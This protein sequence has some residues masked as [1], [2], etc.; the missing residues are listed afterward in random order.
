MFTCQSTAK[1]VGLFNMCGRFALQPG[2]KFYDRFNIENRLDALVERNNITPGQMVPVIMSKSPNRVELMKWGLIPHWA[3]EKN[4][5]YKMINARIE[6]LVEKPS[7]RGPLKSKRCLVPASGFYEWQATRFG[8][9]PYFIH[10]KNEPLFSFAGLYDVW[11][12]G[13]DDGKVE[14]IY[15]FTIITKNANKT[16]SKI[17]DRMP[18]ILEQSRE[19]EWLDR[20][21]QDTIK[22]LSILNC[23][24]EDKI[25]I[26]PADL[27]G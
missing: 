4:I 6:T 23:D 3:K 17:H 27:R 8:K 9:T 10:L 1:V 5:G 26:Y 24:Y 20:D 14:K 7:Y 11:T 21:L 16:I 25:E 2:D 19:S 15:S 12:D 18:V 13:E 22:A